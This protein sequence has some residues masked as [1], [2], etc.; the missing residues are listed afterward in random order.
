MVVS[1][2]LLA[3]TTVY[4]PVAAAAPASVSLTSAAA[5]VPPAQPVPLISEQTSLVVDPGQSMELTLWLNAGDRAEGR[6]TVVPQDI[7][8]TITDPYGQLVLN[9]GL[10]TDKSFDFVAVT[11]G[12]YRL[13]FSNSLFLAAN[14]V[15]SVQVR[16]PGTGQFP[17]FTGV[18][19]PLSTTEV[20]TVTTHLAA[21]QEVSG[22]FQVQGGQRE[23]VF[24]IRGP[25]DSTIEPPAVVV[26]SSTFTFTT[27]A[28]G[29]YKLIFD[30]SAS[31]LTSKLVSLELSNIS[32][33]QWQWAA[34]TTM[35]FI[36]SPAAATAGS[37]F[38][39]QPVVALRD[40]NGKTVPESSAAVTLA[41]T[42]A[43]NPG[44]SVLS[45]TATVNA[46]NGV[47][48]FSG[49]SINVPGN[50]KLTAT[51]SDLNV[52]ITS[53]LTPGTVPTT[54]PISATSGYF[55]V[56]PRVP[57]K[58][59][60]ATSPGG[61]IAGSAFAT[62]PVVVLQ[63]ADGNLMPV[64][65]A[66]VNVAITP[67]TGTAGAVLSGATTVSTFAGVA[68]FNNLAIDLVG[69]GYTLTASSANATATL[70]SANSSAF[71]VI[72]T[73]VTSLPLD[74]GWNLISLPLIPGDAAI[75]SVL[76][77]VLASVI[78][79]W[80]YDAASAR[81]LSYAPAL[82]GDLATMTEGNAYW[83]NMSAPANLAVSGS[84]PPPSVPVPL[85]YPVAA[86][87]N[88]IGFRAMAGKSAGAYL[89]GT[90]Y[91]LPIYGYARGAY[92]TV[93]LSTDSLRPGRGY[94]VYF[95]E[96]GVIKP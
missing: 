72:P 76:D 48:T 42:P 41:I 93:S 50:Y 66:V 58:V 24:S 44:A 70:T 56:S 11:R 59:A 17:Y 4:L 81:W 33:A 61:A 71:N 37:V 74:A 68:T 87:W 65:S 63:D 2:F 94:W 30:N 69:K 7:N 53:S 22:S 20:K 1:V 62:Q 60:F 8:F 29:A 79:V 9:A 77:N 47:A 57:T 91:R 23:V 73:P 51:R 35:A 3:N 16:H 90:R 12:F 95:N 36:A 34:V 45:G 88:M 86:G 25:S 52:T 21:D 26:R 28:A 19:I 64:Y 96:A 49:L 82:G 13:I 27:T 18:H 39:T 75:T 31:S 67:G 6:I 40:A 84:E 43:T 85:S 32:G 10:V 46:V 38:A 15:V 54:Y 78:S 83:V 89:A 80:H 55:I 5:P 14:K 92:S